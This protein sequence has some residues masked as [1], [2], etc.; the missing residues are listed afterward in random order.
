MEAVA[1]VLMFIMA[2]M[3]LMVHADILKMLKKIDE[4]HNGMLLVYLLG[5]ENTEIMDTMNL[6]EEQKQNIEKLMNM[7]GTGL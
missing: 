7:K 6:T 1:I 5:R 3:N 2:I 4:V